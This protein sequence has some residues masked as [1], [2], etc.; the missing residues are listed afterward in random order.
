LSKPP[1]DLILLVRDNMTPAVDNGGAF[2]PDLT[3]TVRFLDPDYPA[4]EPDDL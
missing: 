1:S 3:G 4:V 2:E